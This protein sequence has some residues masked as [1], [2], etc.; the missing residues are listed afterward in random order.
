MSDLVIHNVNVSYDEADERV[1][2]FVKYLKSYDRTEETRK[3]YEE[4]KSSVDKTINLSDQ[5]DNEFTL[6]YLGGH[7]CSLKLRGT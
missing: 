3:Y 6:E 1:R 5:F 7:N 4:V 2:N